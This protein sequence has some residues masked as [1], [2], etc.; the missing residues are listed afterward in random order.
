MANSVHS[1]S[2]AHIPVSDSRAAAFTTGVQNGSWQGETVKVAHSA[3]PTQSDVLDAAEEA[4]Q[5]L[6][7]FKKFTERDVS[8]GKSVYDEIL[9]RIK[10]IRQIESITGVEDFTKSLLNL[11]KESLQSKDLQERVAEKYEDIFHQYIALY[12]AAVAYESQYGSEAA[13]EI[14]AAANELKSK[15]QQQIKER[16]S[17]RNI[18]FDP[19]EA[20]FNITAEASEFLKEHQLDSSLTE[21]RAEYFDHVMDHKTLAGSYNDIIKRHGTGNN[22]ELAVEMQ[23]KLLGGDLNS[24]TLS[25]E[26]AHLTSIVNDMTSLKRLVGIHDKC[27]DTQEQLERNPYNIPF[28]G[29]Q[30]MARMLD[31]LDRSWVSSGDIS[32]LVR[33]MGVQGIEAQTFLANQTKDLVRNIPEEAF[34]DIQNKEQLVASIQDLQ[35]TLAIKESGV[36]EISNTSESIGEV[37]ISG[38]ALE[39]FAPGEVISD[40]ASGG[41]LGGFSPATNAAEEN[42]LIPGILNPPPV[43]A[44]TS[45]DESGKIGQADKSA[46]N[47]QPVVTAKRNLDGLSDKQLLE[48][49]KEELKQAGKIYSK[50][51]EKYVVESSLTALR[52]SLQQNQSEQNILAAL[53][54]ITK[55]RGS[56]FAKNLKISITPADSTKAINLIPPDNAA[57]LSWVAQNDGGLNDL[58]N[59]AIGV[60]EKHFDANCKNLD[61]E[62]IQYDLSVLKDSIEQIDSKMKE[63]P[64]G[65]P[66]G[67]TLFSQLEDEYPLS[68]KVNEDEGLLESSSVVPRSD[69]DK[70]SKIKKYMSR[71]RNG[72]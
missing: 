2:A 57:L 45:A 60:L 52:H 13:A 10:K 1:A 58:V 24:I 72:D 47:D 48:L 25:A 27:M 26:K 18:E 50:K 61:L 65:R 43:D 36:D 23:L 30:Y 66:M 12:E 71:L 40:I 21:V 64:I 41:A 6:S 9:D 7:K 14:F 34:K 35:D 53:K 16:D 28:A 32:G 17:G 3:I 11:P 20:A 37:T 39:N 59:T 4:T 5:M 42:N 54:A 31:I 49:Q 51:D 63:K 22:F 55:K 46:A 44:E 69:K 19:I 8:K 68:I 56:Q 15:Y 38:G 70:K 62:K 67:S 29:S 33:D